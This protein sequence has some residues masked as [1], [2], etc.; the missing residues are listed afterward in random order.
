MGVDIRCAP[1]KNVS[2]KGGDAT[3]YATDL[4]EEAL[5]PLRSD[6]CSDDCGVCEPLTMCYCFSEYAQVN[7]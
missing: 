2:L 4:A 7:L 6:D 5:S 3:H 1:H